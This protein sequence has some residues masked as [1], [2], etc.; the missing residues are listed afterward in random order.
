[1]IFTLDKH[2]KKAQEI[3]REIQEIYTA[4]S[5]KISS[6]PGDPNYISNI[7]KISV[8]I[9]GWLN[10]FN[11]RNRTRDILSQL[12]EQT[13]K[14]NKFFPMFDTEIQFKDARLLLIVNY[15]VSSWALA[16]KIADFVGEILCVDNVT[17]NPILRAK[18]VKNFIQDGSSTPSIIS[19][20]LKESFG[21]P[22]AIAYVIRN[23]FIHESDQQGDLEFF[24]GE[25]ISDGFKISDK[26]WQFIMNKASEHKVI[27]RQMRGTDT[28]SQDNLLNI[29]DIC[30]RE[31]DDALGVLLLTAC[32]LLKT[33]VAS[34]VE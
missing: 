34:L 26:A 15:L 16:D 27:N 17:K 24:A 5:T 12:E 7:L 2:L 32:N 33:L 23:F 4:D 31:M 13:T 20:L 9:D 8:E 28:L 11:T 19:R 18:L 30:H 29:L 10:T 22:I 21:W 14:G 25:D 1:M 6:P 3:L